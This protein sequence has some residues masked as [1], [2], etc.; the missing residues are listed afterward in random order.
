MIGT[1]GGMIA[2]VDMIMIEAETMVMIADVI[3]EGKVSPVNRNTQD[4]FR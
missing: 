3:Q 2:M 4:Y 1:E